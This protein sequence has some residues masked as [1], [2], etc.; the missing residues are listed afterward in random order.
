M[1]VF[2]ITMKVAVWLLLLALASARFFE[3]S[4]KFSLF[5]HNEGWVYVDKMTFAPGTA[6]V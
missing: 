3:T 6:R 1:V 4:I 2:I 5:G